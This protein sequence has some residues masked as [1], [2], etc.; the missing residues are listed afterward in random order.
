MMEWGEPIEP[1]SLLRRGPLKR[2]SKHE[3]ALDGADPTHACFHAGVHDAARRHSGRTGDLSPGYPAAV[4]WH[5]SGGVGKPV[6]RQRFGAC[7]RAHIGV[8]AWRYSDH[9]LAAVC[10]GGSPRV[11][12]LQ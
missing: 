12:S 8:L 11:E 9:K 7:G 4:G 2:A 1:V 10:R 5:R 3:V 6:S